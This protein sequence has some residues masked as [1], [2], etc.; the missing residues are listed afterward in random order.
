[1]AGHG[2][3]GFGDQ[4]E[5]LLLHDGGSDGE[6]LAGAH[7]VGDVGLAG[8]DDAPDHALLVGAQLDRRGSPGQLQ[9][10]AG[11]V[12]RHQAVEGIVVDAYQPF[13]AVAV[14]PD[15]A[16][17][18]PLDLRQLVLGRLSLLG[19]ELAVLA[20]RVAPDVPDLR[21]GGVQGIVQQL[22]GMAAVRAPFRGGG[23]LARE[24]VDLD[25]PVR[26]L[27]GV[28][29]HG[30]DP[31]HLLNEGGDVAGRDP[32]GAEP[33]SDVGGPQV[34]RL[35]PLQRRHVAGVA[36]VQHGGGPG[37]GEL[38]ADVTRQVLVGGLPGFEALGG[39]ARIEEHGLAQLGQHRRPVAP[40]QLGDVVEIHGPALGQRHRQGVGGRDDDRLGRGVDHPVGE[41]RA[42]A[43]GARLQ[44]VLLDGGDQPAVGIIEE[45][46]QVGPAHALAHLPRRLVGAGRDG[47]EV[48][49]SE[50]AHEAAIG[51]AQ[52][53]LGGAERLVRLLG[54]DHL[55]HGVADRDQAAD[56]AGVLGKEAD[57]ALAG[58]H[59][60]L[61]GAAV[62][63]LQQ[64]PA[65]AEQV[66]AFLDRGALGGGADQQ[67]WL[68]GPHGR[69]GR[70]RGLVDAFGQPG[71]GLGQGGV[72]VA[73][74]AGAVIGEAERPAGPAMAAE[75]HLRVRR[76]AGIGV[77][78]GLAVGC[79]DHLGEMRPLHPVR[80]GAALAALQEEDVHH[81]VGAGRRREGAR[82]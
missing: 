48:D 40:E 61:L 46:L 23:R 3:H 57:R 54:A 22:A 34:L 56:D 17:E 77:D 78:G 81:H 14:G 79:R 37:G 32:R 52:P 18:G 12:T 76:E 62:H 50:G 42:P 69:R 11:E 10:L 33:G 8:G 27:H 82:R 47:G 30:P 53:H 25:A 4:A 13:G 70:R 59:R 5:A 16:L 35:H 21:D 65:L 43:R 38:A 71:D 1:M 73:A 15:P 31:H 26:H 29:H 67:T 55:A 58:L 2:Q 60:H 9:V 28:P 7:G 80:G 45:G 20:V 63:H 6:G 36:P 64:R 74:V 68:R 75:H 44:V 51:G 39:Q 19:V 66:G 49:R 24:A 41:D 72:E